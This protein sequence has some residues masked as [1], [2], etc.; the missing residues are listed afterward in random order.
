MK[1]QD[2]LNVDYRTSDG[3]RILQKALFKILAIKKNC[4]EEAEVDLEVIEKVIGIICRKYAIAIQ[5]ISPNYIEGQSNLYCISV[6]STDDH[7]WLGNVY[8][9]CIYEAMAKCA[10]KM[11][12]EVKAGNVGLQDWDKVRQSVRGIVNED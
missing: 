1:T 5:Y 7:R 10:I 11:Y 3:K 2:I 4:F 12:S 8:G 9:Y 6:K